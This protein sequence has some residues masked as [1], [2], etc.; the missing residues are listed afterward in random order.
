MD[1]VEA[2]LRADAQRRQAMIAADTVQ[3]E[4]RLSDELT[5]THSSGRTEGKREIIH[6]ITSK[7]VDYLSLETADV[8]VSEHNQVFICHGT[9]LGLASRNGVE[10]ELRNKFLSVWHQS[11]SS[12]EMLA[13]QS[14]GF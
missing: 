1:N 3:L 12:F 6:A 7:S 11:G 10:K 9:L 14:T 8:V 4:K 13:W 2:L 5:W